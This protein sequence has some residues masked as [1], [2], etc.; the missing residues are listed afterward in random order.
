MVSGLKSAAVC[1]YDAQ[2][3]Q[4]KTDESKFFSNSILDFVRDEDDCEEVDH[5]F[6]QL[7]DKV[8]TAILDSGSSDERRAEPHTLLVVNSS[9]RIAVSCCN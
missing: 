3:Q 4:V 7:T 9:A 2:F 5:L 8:F 1:S 6:E